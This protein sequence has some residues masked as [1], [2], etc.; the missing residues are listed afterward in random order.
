MICSITID[1][2]QKLNEGTG[3]IVGA[4]RA[5]SVPIVSGAVNMVKNTT[6]SILGNVG[7]DLSDGFD[8]FPVQEY[9]INIEAPIYPTDGMAEKENAEEMKEK[10][11]E[12]WKEVYED[13]YGIPLEYTT[14]PKAQQEQITE[15]ETQI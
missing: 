2:K 5:F 1:V 4:I 8:G 12:V 3:F 9:Y 13:F 11:S 6:N 15:Q 14:T 10:N 7:I